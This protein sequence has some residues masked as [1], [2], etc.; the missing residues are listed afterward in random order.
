[1]NTE[2]KYLRKDD[3]MF[4]KTSYGFQFFKNKLQDI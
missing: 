3:Y 4:Y 1:M 2:H